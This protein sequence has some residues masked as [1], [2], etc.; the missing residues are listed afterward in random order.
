MIIKNQ[1]MYLQIQ[2]DENG[3]IKSIS[4]CNPELE[5]HEYTEING[6]HTPGFYIKYPTHTN[7]HAKFKINIIQ[8]GMVGH[9]PR[10]KYLGSKDKDSG[11]YSK[12]T[13]DRD[14]KVVIGISKPTSSYSSVEDDCIDAVVSFIAAKR[15]EIG[16]FY[17]DRNNKDIDYIRTVADEYNEMSK[18]EKKKYTKIGYKELY[19]K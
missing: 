3:K 12:L 8:D 11:E 5:L 18:E 19:N 14:S 4:Q 15:N 16:E 1:P 10:V 9:G 6:G 17:L 2:F 13:L 7:K